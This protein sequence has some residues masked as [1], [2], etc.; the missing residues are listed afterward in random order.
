[1]PNP[2]STILRTPGAARRLLALLLSALPLGMLS[3]TII[4]SVQ[5][6]TGSLRAAG[7]VSALFGLGN[8]IGLTVQGALMER[9]GER[10]LLLVTGTSCAVAL[11]MFTTVGV[12]EGPLWA[13]GVLAL[14]GGTCVPA[15]TAAAR[16]WLPLAF[17]E[18]TERSAS[19]ALLAALF[20]TAVAVGPLLLSLAL[21]LH[22]PVLA[23]ALSATAILAAVLVFALPRDERRGPD[24]SAADVEPPRARRVDPERRAA[25]RSRL[26]PG[27]LTILCAEALG[28]IAV[29]ATGVAVP[30]AMDSAGRPVLVGVGFA[31]LACGEVLT[32]LI[33]GARPI[34]T[35][36]RMILPLA[37]AGSAFSA[38][39]VLL[40]AASPGLLVLAMMIL[41]ASTAPATLAKSAL[42]DVVSTADAV[43]RGY[44]Q[45][46]AVS[47][48]SAAAGSA[49]AGQLSDAL[50]PLGLLVV[51]V[52]SLGL[53]AAW[54]AS[55]MRTLR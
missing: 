17:A 54:T 24:T 33:I 3:L 32:A 23:L 10:G 2:Y 25:R 46:V 1:M 49:L 51:P 12:L 38:L 9:R 5:E 42:L 28:G 13:L 31:A 30:A 19:Y 40:S 47:L 36:R 27:M 6:W 11:A 44:S 26:S 22:G 16:A 53:A 34:P 21:L 55:R 45:L 8:A 20:Q 41:G 37:L 43:A 35:H 7:T 52:A 4:L 15:I 29:G 14:T 50:S 18:P 39:L 48:I